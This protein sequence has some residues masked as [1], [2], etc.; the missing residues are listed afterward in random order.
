MI[1]FCAHI[2]RVRIRLMRQRNSC[3]FQ[4]FCTFGSYAD[5]NY[6]GA[7]LT[8]DD[9]DFIR[10]I[11]HDISLS[12]A[13]T[14]FCRRFVPVRFQRAHISRLHSPERRRKTRWKKKRSQIARRRNPSPCVRFTGQTCTRTSSRGRTTARRAC[15]FHPVVVSEDAHT[16]RRVRGVYFSFVRR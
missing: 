9:R 13:N 14:G 11:T 2:N 12:L 1:L 6:A 8:V 16:P 4:T 10:V 7:F 5:R 15:T 3:D